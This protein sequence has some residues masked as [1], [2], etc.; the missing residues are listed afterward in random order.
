MWEVMQ[1]SGNSANFVN[2]KIAAG[3][4]EGKFRGNDRGDG[5]VYKTIEA[6]AMVYLHTKDSKLDQTMDEAI[7]V[8]AKAQTPEGYIGTQIQLTGTTNRLKSL[9]TLRLTAF[10]NRISV[11]F[12]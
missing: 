2:L 3:L 4:A 1:D 10:D 9:Q 12:R 11:N 6:M 8:I 5:D 7:S